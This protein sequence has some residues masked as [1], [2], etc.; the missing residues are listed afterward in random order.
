MTSLFEVLAARGTSEP[1]RVFL[2]V[3]GG[4]TWTYGALDRLV[5]RMGA[6]LLES[7]GGPGERVM[8]QVG[9]SPEAVALYLATLRIGAI[10]CPL[11]TAYTPA[12]VQYFVGDASPAVFVGSDDR[13]RAFSPAGT[14]F[15]T[16]ASDGGGT[17]MDCVGEVLASPDP[18]PG[19]GSSVVAMLYTSGTTGRSKGAMLTSDNLVSNAL[20][21]HEI[22]RWDD[23]DVLLHALPIFHVHGLFVALH[24]AMLGASRVIFVDRFSVESTLGLLPMA[25]VMMGVP[26]FYHRLLADER[27][28][29]DRVANMRLFTSGSAPLSEGVHRSFE[30]RTGHRILE[31]YGMT[32]AG[33]ITSNPYDGA[34]IAGTVGYP[35]P[36]VEV[37]VVDDHGEVS[38]PGNPGAVEVRGPNVF[39]GYWQMSERTAAEFRPDGFFRT[40]DVGTLQ[41]DGRLTLAGRSSDMVITGGLNV[42]PKEVEIVLDEVTEVEESAVVGVPHVDLGE[43][44][45][46]FV[47]GSAD[48]S[49][50]AATCADRL[51]AFKRPKRYIYVDALPRNAMGKVQKRELR[52]VGART[53]A[54]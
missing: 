52:D 38:A 27:L 51:A 3:P 43:A 24:C 30:E 5:G 45:V 44:V 6:A 32:E 33:M 47:V 22:W 19:G 54:W 18:T 31:R 13:A 16:L 10:Y 1:D 20:A 40:G 23:R 17:L 7:G 28:T 39:A 46:A 29:A 42:Y 36:G 2:D 14:H 48:E 8:V 41:P 50:L 15:L 49:L 35:L 53:L 4:A 9:K 37:R 12:E 26:T 34:R 21:L 25:T 11:N